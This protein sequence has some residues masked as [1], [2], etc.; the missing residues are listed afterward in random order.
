VFSGDTGEVIHMNTAIKDR[1]EALSSVVD[2]FLQKQ[3]R[4]NEKVRS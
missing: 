2:F 3:N 1:V 4:T